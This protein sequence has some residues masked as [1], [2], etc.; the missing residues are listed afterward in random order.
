LE[1]PYAD[2]SRNY[3]KKSQSR[4]GSEHNASMKKLNKIYNGANNERNSN[5]SGNTVKKNYSQ[6]RLKNANFS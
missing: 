3:S 1:S 5:A 6:D 4:S 2:R